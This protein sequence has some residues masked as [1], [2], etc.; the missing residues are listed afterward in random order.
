M[1][2]ARDRPS[3]Q[4]SL[5]FLGLQHGH[6]PSRAIFRRTVMF[7]SEIGRTTEN[8]CKLSGT[9]TRK[10]SKL[11]YIQENKP[12]AKPSMLLQRDRPNKENKCK[13]SRTRSAT[14]TLQAALLYFEEDGTSAK[15]RTGCWNSA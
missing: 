6:I 14:E 9:A 13:L 15:G 4:T 2:S 10:H 5:S 8:K 11:R 1:L 7:Y 12:T 3:N